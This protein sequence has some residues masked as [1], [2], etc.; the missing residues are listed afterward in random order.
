MNTAS[1]TEPQ[2]S[3]YGPVLYEGELTLPEG[4]P[5]LETFLD[6][7]GWGKVMFYSRNILCLLF[8]LIYGRSLPVIDRSK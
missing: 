1:H 7:S 6:T 2:T 4:Q 3:D 5:P 8:D